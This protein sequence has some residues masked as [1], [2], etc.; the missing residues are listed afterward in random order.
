VGDTAL[1]FTISKRSA[2]IMR[3]HAVSRAVIV[4]DGGSIF[5]HALVRGNEIRLPV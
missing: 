3:K 5:L 1:P 2:S 4:L